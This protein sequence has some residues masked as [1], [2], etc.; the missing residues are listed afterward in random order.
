MHVHEV[1]SGA[2]RRGASSLNFMLA[3]GQ[4]SPKKRVARDCLDLP[5]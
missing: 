2:V 5:F 1:A 3:V 4:S